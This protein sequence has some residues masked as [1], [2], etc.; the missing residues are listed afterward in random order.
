MKIRGVTIRN[1]IMLA[2]MNQ[3]RAV[4]GMADD[5]LLVHL[6]KFALGG[7]GCL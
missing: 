7:A 4:N 3:H 2:P 1:R 5:R 6:G